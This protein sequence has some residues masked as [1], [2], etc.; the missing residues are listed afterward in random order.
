MARRESVGMDLVRMER[1]RRERERERQAWELKDP[2]V[3]LK[4]LNKWYKRA[5]DKMS[6][7][8]DELMPSSICG[9]FRV[10]NSRRAL[11][12]AFKRCMIY[13]LELN[14][15]FWVVRA[16]VAGVLRLFNAPDLQRVVL[17]FLGG[18]EVERRGGKFREEF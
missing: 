12:E 18:V 4:D 8:V 2:G 10:E 3:Y 6:K 17:T 11:M 1:A 16:N 15:P 9:N 14:A 5:E 13:E 7:F